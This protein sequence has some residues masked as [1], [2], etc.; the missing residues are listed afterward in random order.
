MSMG[1]V[2]GLETVQIDVGHREQ[3]AATQGQGQC[4]AHAVAQQHAV[5]QVGEGVVV[6]NALQLGLVFL[7]RGDI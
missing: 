6:G 2:D 4:L 7:G 5:G 1:I 3:L